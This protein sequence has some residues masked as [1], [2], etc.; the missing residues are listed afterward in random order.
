VIILFT[1]MPYQNGDD[2][3]GTPAGYRDNLIDVRA[4]GV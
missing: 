2:S 1:A 4:Y 3:T